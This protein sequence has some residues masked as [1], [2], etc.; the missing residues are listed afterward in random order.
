[1]LLVCSK[2]LGRTWFSF[3]HLEAAS[4]DQGISSFIERRTKPCRHHIPSR[5]ELGVDLTKLEGSCWV[6]FMHSGPREQLLMDQ[7]RY[8]G[9]GGVCGRCGHACTHTAHPPHYCAP[10][11]HWAFPLALPSASV[12]DESKF[13]HRPRRFGF[14]HSRE[15]CEGGVCPKLERIKKKKKSNGERTTRVEGRKDEVSILSRFPSL[16]R[17]GGSLDKACR[18]T[19]LASLRDSDSSRRPHCASC[20]LM[21]MEFCLVP[22]PCVSLVD[23]Q[24]NIGREFACLRQERAKHYAIRG[25]SHWPFPAP[26][27]R[28]H[29]LVASYTGKPQRE[30]AL[31]GRCD[32]DPPACKPARFEM[33][34]GRPTRL[35]DHLVLLNTSFLRF[36]FLLELLPHIIGG[37]DAGLSRCPRQRLSS[38]RS[39][40][41]LPLPF[42]ATEA[43]SFDTQPQTR[44]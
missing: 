4:C 28:V 26:S 15:R 3:A 43:C 18:A 8:A 31:F 22:S 25:R 14:G 24:L 33:E 1:M 29:Y 9:E 11:A 17:P 2:G 21:H 44:K 19:L 23:L 30:G 40:F 32:L 41:V 37:I 35:P 39:V 5:S 42:R 20:D 16:A 34:L 6:R 36:L 27:S 10:S 38:F 7:S 12:P 13:G